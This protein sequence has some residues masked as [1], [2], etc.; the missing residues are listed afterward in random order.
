MLHVCTIA[1]STM[2]L[3]AVRTAEVQ[4]DRP[5]GY[6]PSRSPNILPTR[7]IS[8]RAGSNVHVETIGVHS[9][10]SASNS[11]HFWR[12]GFAVLSIGL[13]PAPAAANMRQLIEHF[14][15]QGPWSVP[16]RM[17]CYGRID[18]E[19][20]NAEWRSG[21]LHYAYGI[22]TDVSK[23]TDVRYLHASNFEGRITLSIGP[24]FDLNDHHPGMT[25]S[26]RLC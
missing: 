8:V 1:P 18:I 9:S 14:R 3:R 16:T 24:Y 21:R 15:D 19:A 6:R 25:S 20:G 23:R 11:V 10:S 13:L 26:Y 12:D 5:L 22:I 17:R 7:R 4:I 2:R